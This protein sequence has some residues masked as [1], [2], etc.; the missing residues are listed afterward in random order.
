MKTFDDG[1]YKLDVTHNVKYRVYRDIN[2]QTIPA[3]DNS[4]VHDTLYY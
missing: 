2:N 1:V 3:S 4:Y